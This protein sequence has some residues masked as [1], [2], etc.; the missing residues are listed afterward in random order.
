MHDYQ[1]RGT[2]ASDRRV[3]KTSP[4]VVP[5]FQSCEAQPCTNS[6]I[7]FRA[8]SKRRWHPQVPVLR[9]DAS[10]CRSFQTVSDKSVGLAF[11]GIGAAQLL[12]VTPNSGGIRDN[13]IEVE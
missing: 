5:R 9:R 8:N 6:M 2:T 1:S 10:L 13:V 11:G 12:A 7:M 4:A 3:C